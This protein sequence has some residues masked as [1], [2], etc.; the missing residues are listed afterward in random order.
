MSILTVVAV[1]DSAVGAYG[2]PVFVPSRGVA[3]R[4]FGDEINRSAPDNQMHHHPEDFHMVALATFDEE[5]GM[6]VNESPQITLARGKDL[7]VQS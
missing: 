7:V 5:T 1:F 3:I 2:R 4:S 6:F